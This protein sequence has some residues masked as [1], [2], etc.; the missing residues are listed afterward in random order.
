MGRKARIEVN[1]QTNIFG[2][3]IFT[4]NVPKAKPKKAKEPAIKYSW[5]IYAVPR[6]HDYGRRTAVIKAYSEEQAKYLFEQ[7]NRDYKVVD[8]YRID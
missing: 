4:E 5:S 7:W 3:V 2:E 6:F 1:G 8:I